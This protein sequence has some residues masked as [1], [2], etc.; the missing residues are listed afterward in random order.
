MS[1]HWLDTNSR[2]P[3]W[4]SAFPRFLLVPM[5]LQESHSI[6]TR[7]KGMGED[8]IGL[9]GSP[10]VAAASERHDA[11]DWNATHTVRDRLVARCITRTSRV[12][13]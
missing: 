11:S 3:I 5:P 8:F 2:V 9:K 7:E 13:R 10:Q 6:G 12:C 4:S 1:A